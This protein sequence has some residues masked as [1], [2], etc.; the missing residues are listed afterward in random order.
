MSTSMLPDA[1]PAFPP[2][3]EEIP[4]LPL[5]LDVRSRNVLLVGGGPAAAAK[6]ELLL[7]CRARVLVVAERLGESLR[8]LA[9]SG[10]V[11][12]HGTVFESSMLDEVALVFDGAGEPELTALLRRET[13]ARGLL[14]NVV[15]RPDDCDFIVPARL[16]R[17]PITVAISTGGAAPAFAR[18][19]RQQLELAI[20]EGY[21]RIA[22]AAR[23]CRESV[24]EKLPVSRARQRFWDRVLQPSSLKELSRLGEDE[25][26]SRM[27]A[28][29]AGAEER[30]L[31]S[32]ALVGAGP[33]DPELLTLK[34][35]RAIETADVI[36]H[37]ALVPAAI[38]E[39]ARR[40]ARLVSVGKRA[41][42]ASVDQALTN[43][44]MAV[45][46]QRGERV[47]RLK[48]GDPLVF[49]RGGEEAAYLR[50]RGVPVSIVPGITAAS[51]IGAELQLPLTH[52]GVARSVRYVTA[53]CR[54]AEETG[55]IDW[56]QLA[57]PSTTL[58]VYMGR[59]QAGRIAAALMGAGMPGS[60]AAAAIE[61]GTLSHSRH[62][63]ARLSGLGDAVAGLDA[64][65]PVLLLIGD[66]VAEAPGWQSPGAAREPTG[67]VPSVAVG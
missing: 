56:R 25:I 41:G 24:K 15:D 22:R 58:A 21:G 67:P 42:R 57:D 44:M 33:G 26:L 9:A 13:R 31:G 14:L 29:V 63:F 28:A 48:G 64:S 12:W 60:T 51:G 53:Q 50:E 18:A 19:I 20:P 17:G 62:R 34:A 8:D 49:G 36:F 52:R 46:A 10:D 38:L 65:A 32:V 2:G 55:R 45:A 59:G 39:I 61:N 16:E 43:R 3:S 7:R 6:A 1:S 23:R 66:A 30:P 5:F 27:E 35:V 37:D 4:Y 40:E 11:C 47:V 54:N